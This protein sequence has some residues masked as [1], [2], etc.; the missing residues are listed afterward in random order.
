MS[1]NPSEE[2]GCLAMVICLALIGMWCF[3]WYGLGWEKSFRKSFNN[4]LDK[5]FVAK[6]GRQ[7]QRRD[8]YI[9]P[10][11]EIVPIPVPVPTPA[12]SGSKVNP[13]LLYPS[14]PLPEFTP[15]VGMPNL[16]PSTSR[17]KKVRCYEQENMFGGGYSTVC[18]EF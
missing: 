10:S 5:V 15:P 12:L 13:S 17:K 1:N 3:V 2:H 8:V 11:K 9:P 7:D 4:W 6:P 18:E 14:Q 16:M